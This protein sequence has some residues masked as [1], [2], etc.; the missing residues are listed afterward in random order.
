MTDH[1]TEAS[2][3]IN[4]LEILVGQNEGLDSVLAQAHATLALAEQQRIANLIALA[5][6]DSEYGHIALEKFPEIAR[7]LRIETP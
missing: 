7:A 4:G 3:L 6:A 5:E 1:Y 2:R